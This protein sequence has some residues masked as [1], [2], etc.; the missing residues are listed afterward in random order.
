MDPSVIGAARFTRVR[1]ACPVA[2]PAAA[3]ASATRLPSGTRT[4]PGAETAPATCTTSSVPAGLH[5]TAQP[6]CRTAADRRQQALLP[7][8]A[9]QH[10]WPRKWI[11][12]PRSA[13]RRR[14]GRGAKAPP[15]QPPA[16]GRLRG[17][18]HAA[19]TSSA[20]GSPVRRTAPGRWLHV[21]ARQEGPFPPRRS[22]GQRG[23][24]P[25]GRVPLRRMGRGRQPGA[26]P[27]AGR[28]VLPAVR[29][30]SGG[31]PWL[32]AMVPG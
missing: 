32:H 8:A 18:R 24:I 5:R 13:R 31:W 15:R 10:W 7:P 9:P 22:P 27:Q 12:A 30:P 14:H 4:S 17:F 21:P 28:A 2:P 29:Y 1:S 16:S 6:C 26:A 3:T 20:A 19:E 23:C 11:P 25:S